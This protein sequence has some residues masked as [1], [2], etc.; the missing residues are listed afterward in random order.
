VT[1]TTN[2]FYTV[3]LYSWAYGLTDQRKPEYRLSL[4]VEGTGGQISLLSSSQGDEE[5]SDHTT[6]SYAVE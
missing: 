5:D 3:A 6:M 2:T 4:T 1:T